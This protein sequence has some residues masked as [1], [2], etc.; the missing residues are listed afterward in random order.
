MVDRL[1]LLGAYE[2]F[3][4]AL[5]GPYEIGDV[6][7][8]LTDRVVEVLSIEGAGV[9]L[10]RDGGDL[11][12]ITSSDRRAAA[13]EDQQVAM[14][15]GPCHEAFRSNRQVRI[16]DLRED[17]PWPGY[18]EVALRQGMHAVA[19]LPMPVGERRL[20]ALDLY[21][22][23]PTPWN[24]DEIRVAQ[25]LA[26]MASGYILNN[27]ELSQSRTLTE[28]LQSALDSRVIVEQAKGVLSGRT[29]ITTN[30]AFSRLRDHARTTN[31]KLRDV[32]RRVVEGE[33]DL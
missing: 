28:Q 4:E 25:V 33:L 10:A 19:S 5:L 21:R 8:R 11:K 26:N 30:E 18:C 3:A 9:C 12:L 22:V 2:D 1:A 20:G 16:S 13:I 15:D 31:A 7:Y 17:C 14:S 24:D 23:E 27:L 6:L 29:G 32:C